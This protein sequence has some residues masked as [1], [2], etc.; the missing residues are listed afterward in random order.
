MY[1]SVVCTCSCL[2]GFFFLHSLRFHFQMVD[3][4]PL[5]PAHVPA[6]LVPPGPIPPLAK[7]APQPALQPIQAG[8]PIPAQQQPIPAPQPLPAPLDVAPPLPL[9]GLQPVAAAKAV[10][11]QPPVVQQAKVRCFSVVIAPGWLI[12]GPSWL[13]NCSALQVNL[14]S[15]FL[16]CFLQLVGAQAPSAAVVAK[17]KPVHKRAVA[18]GG[19]EKQQPKQLVKKR[20]QAEADLQAGPAAKVSKV[21]KV[22]SAFLLVLFVATLQL[23]G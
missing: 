7:P 20:K 12:V 19:G 5:L 1:R 14:E 16:S 15:D 13:L 22:R 8:Q 6:F 2:Q 4:S 11:G 23:L 18:K 10:A 17:K 9:A 21:G 3:A